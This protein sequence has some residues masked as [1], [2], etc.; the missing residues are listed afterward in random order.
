MASVLSCGLTGSGTLTKAA[1]ADGGSD[2][3]ATAADA[4]AADAAS[5]DSAA[6]DDAATAD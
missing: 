4:I 1:P 3:S 6:A 5:A 2:G